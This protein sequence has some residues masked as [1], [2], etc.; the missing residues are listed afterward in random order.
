M[1]EANRLMVF[2]RKL[3][4]VN[5]C[6]RMRRHI[7]VRIYIMCEYRLICASSAKAGE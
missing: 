3:K 7:N 6:L 1:F 4:G 2:P 5:R